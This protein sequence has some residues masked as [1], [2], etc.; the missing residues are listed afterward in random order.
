M[1]SIYNISCICVTNI[2]TKIKE[3]CG[4]FLKTRSIG[5]MMLNANGRLHIHR[6]MHHSVYSFLIIRH[7]AVIFFYTSFLEDVCAYIAPS[8][9]KTDRKIFLNL[10]S[11]RP[12]SIYLFHLCNIVCNQNDQYHII[13]CVVPCI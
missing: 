4:L 1:N 10:V 9:E 5:I 8:S 3:M 13:V 2:P 12:C 6:Y 11:F 7:F